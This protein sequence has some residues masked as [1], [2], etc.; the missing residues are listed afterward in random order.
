MPDSEVHEAAADHAQPMGE[1][2][3]PA[4]A[5]QALL[6]DRGSTH[7]SFEN[8]ARVSQYIKRAFRNESG[9]HGLTD[10]EREAMD[11]IALKF[12]RL[13]SGKSLEKQHWEDVVGYAQLALNQCVVE[14]K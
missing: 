4:D 5:S 8:N 2:A 9:W 14:A 13:L 11:M 7:G 6:A 1:P 3:R 12:S 10:V